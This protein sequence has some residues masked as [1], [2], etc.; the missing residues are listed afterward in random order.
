MGNTQ[1]VNASNK[2]KPKKLATTNQK[3]PCLNNCSIREES[4][5][6]DIEAPATEF[7]EL[8]AAL[9]SASPKLKI[10]LMGG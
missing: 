1:G 2:P 4:D 10:L 7:A 8:G 9:A 5:S 3:P 6:G